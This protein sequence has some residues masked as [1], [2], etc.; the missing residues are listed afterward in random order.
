LLLR[1]PRDLYCT[2][3]HNPCRK[4]H[5]VSESAIH[6]PPLFI[7]LNGMVESYVS[8]VEENMKIIST[9]QR[10]WDERDKHPN[11]FKNSII[12]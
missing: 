5:N 3:G 1:V 7:Q 8:T 2:Q 4:C 12:P 11:I 10:G 6:P 9:N